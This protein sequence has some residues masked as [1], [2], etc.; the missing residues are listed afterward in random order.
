M[1]P[2]CAQTNWNNLGINMKAY[3]WYRVE[4]ILEKED[5]LSHCFQKSSVAEASEN[6]CMLER[7]KAKNAFAILKQAMQIK[8]NGTCDLR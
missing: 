4:N 7:V 1:Y 2:I 3:F 5:I 6:V 8:R